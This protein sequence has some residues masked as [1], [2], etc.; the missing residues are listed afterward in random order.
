M[1]LAALLTIIISQILILGISTISISADKLSFI[2]TLVVVLIVAFASSA[3]LRNIQSL[4]V[5]NNY[6]ISSIIGVILAIFYYLWA[7]ENVNATVDWLRETGIY[8]LMLFIVLAA[9]VLFFTKSK[10]KSSSVA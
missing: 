8:F 2:S 4:K 6:I 9:L 10:D 7:K 5:R 1:R 3:L